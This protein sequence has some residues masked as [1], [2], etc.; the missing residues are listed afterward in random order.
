MPRILIEYGSTDGQTAK[1]CYFLAGELMRL[2]S[3]VDIE[4]AGA[5]TADPSAY[6]GIIVAASIHAGGYQKAI[7]QWARQHAM[8]L[9]YKPAVFLSVSLGILEANPK[10]R[11]DLDRI[12]D[13][14]AHRSGWRPAEVKEVAGALK[15]TRYGWLK[16][17]VMRHIAGKAGGSTDMSRDHEY[18][19]WDDL[20]AFGAR[21]LGVAAR[22]KPRIMDAPPGR[23]RRI[24]GGLEAG[25]TATAP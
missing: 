25:R 4:E 3:T 9:A 12:L 7:V 10:T 5:G 19:D 24:P 14:F 21:L 2:G 22:Q 1:I 13:D 23:G 8:V 6:D 15:Y 16:R 20:R 17:R 18:T 11:A